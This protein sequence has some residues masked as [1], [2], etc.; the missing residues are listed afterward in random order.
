MDAPVLLRFP[1]L[2]RSHVACE[3][4]RSVLR[5][6]KVFDGIVKTAQEANVTDLSKTEK[7]LPDSA[8]KREVNAKE[9]G[10]KRV[11]DTRTV[12]LMGSRAQLPC[13]KVTTMRVEHI[14]TVRL[15]LQVF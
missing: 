14:V 12:R 9:M 1:L 6:R 10:R 5:S 8:N 11:N 13:R 7:V 4:K 15:A 3:T 2:L